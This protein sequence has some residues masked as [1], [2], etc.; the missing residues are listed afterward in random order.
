MSERLNNF[1]IEEKYNIKPNGI[2][3]PQKK[4][5]CKHCV[6]REKED[7]CHVIDTS[8]DKVYSCRA[9]RYRLRKL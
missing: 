5:F 4:G 9:Y 8:C 2:T 6:Y 7:Y 1:F 3:K